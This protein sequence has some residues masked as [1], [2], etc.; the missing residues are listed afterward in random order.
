MHA[1]DGRLERQQAIEN[2]RLL[3]KGEPALVVYRP[4]GTQMLREV[5]LVMKAASTR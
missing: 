3:E 4:R 1:C 2:F 5:T